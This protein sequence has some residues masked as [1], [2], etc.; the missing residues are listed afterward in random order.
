MDRD[1]MRELTHTSL[2]RALAKLDALKESSR[3]DRQSKKRKKRCEALASNA[4][5]DSRRCDNTVGYEREGFLVCGAH[6]VAARI[7]CQ[8]WAND[9]AEF[10]LRRWKWGKWRT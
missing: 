8:R 6:F 10:G 4:P 5:Y 9:Q 3:L 2:L 7:N 1:S